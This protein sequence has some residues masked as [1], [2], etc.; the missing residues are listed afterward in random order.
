MIDF[1]SIIILHISR[2]VII[3]IVGINKIRKAKKERIRQPAK[4][5]DEED[6]RNK[7]MK[8]QR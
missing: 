5:E 7:N 2:F 6:R 4:D 1:I 3:Y 8:M